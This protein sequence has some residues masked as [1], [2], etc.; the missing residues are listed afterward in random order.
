[1][2]QGTPPPRLYSERTVWPGPFGRDHQHVEIGARLDQVEMD[3]E[4]VGEHQRRAFLHVGRKFAAIDVGLQLVGRQHHHDVG[5]FGRAGD[6]HH[7]DSLRLRLLDGGRVRPQRNGYVL[8]AAVAHVEQMRMTL[9]A[10]ADDGHL[11][12]LDQIEIGVPVVVNAHVLSW[13]WRAK[14]G[15][16]LKPGSGAGGRRADGLLVK[17]GDAIKRGPEEARGRY[18]PKGTKPRPKLALEVG[19]IAAGDVLLALTREASG[20]RPAGGCQ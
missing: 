16:E 15:F 13:V 10:V 8:D 14:H 9:A 12:A 4:A 19:L 2:R 6:V 1:M 3:V 17:A 11:L 7:L 20:S 18:A 5:P